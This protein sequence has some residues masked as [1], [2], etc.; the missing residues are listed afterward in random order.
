MKRKKIDFNSKN[1]KSMLRLNN[2][3]LTTLP[4]NLT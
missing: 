3:Q 4:L 1:V 2:G